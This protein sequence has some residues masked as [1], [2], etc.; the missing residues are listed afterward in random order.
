MSPDHNRCILSD[1]HCNTKEYSRAVLVMATLMPAAQQRVAI[2]GERSGKMKH[3]ARPNAAPAA[4]KGKMNPPR[5]PPA[6][7]KEFYEGADPKI[8]SAGYHEG[9]TFYELLD[10][11]TKQ[12]NGEMPTVDVDDGLLAV[13]LG[14]AA[15][16]SI[17]EMRI[18]E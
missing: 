9:A 5:Y 13:T 10:F 11:V 14:V 6:T 7:V 3:R 17:D 4:K 2:T 1:P 8:L 12:V 16:K 15:H 18:C